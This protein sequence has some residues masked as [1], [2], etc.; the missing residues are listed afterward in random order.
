M[1][2]ISNRSEPLTKEELA[3]LFVIVLRLSL[4]AFIRWTISHNVLSVTGLTTWI[5]FGEFTPFFCLEAILLVDIFFVGNGVRVGQTAYF[6]TR[7]TLSG[8]VW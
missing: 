2:K 8:P 4:H 1:A 6:T 7:R 5:A 3:I